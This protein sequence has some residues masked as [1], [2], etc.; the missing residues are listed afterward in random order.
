MARRYG[1]RFSGLI[2]R[3]AQ[4]LVVMSLLIAPDVFAQARHFTSCVMNTGN[5]ATVLL[6]L[7]DLPM[8]GGEF[9]SQ[10][11]EIAVFTQDGICVG[12][13]VW[14]GEVMAFA[15]WGDDEM[16]PDKQEGLRADDVLTFKIWDASTGIEYTNVELEF[17]A[18]GTLLRSDGRYA[19]DHVYKVTGMR[20]VGTEDTSANGLPTSFSL[21]QNYPNPFNPQT[22]IRY[23]L[24]VATKVTLE[25]YDLIGRRVSVLYSGMQEAGYHEVSFRGDALPSG[26]YFYRLVA[27]GKKESRMMQLAK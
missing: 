11:D 8:I 26:T 12:S 19:P 15:I 23:G 27:G 22:T 18:E 9:L 10:G 16:T 25:V 24:P 2:R 7:E 14:E 3:V 6:A 20:V 21:D 17:D 5:N 4:A 1:L 13:G